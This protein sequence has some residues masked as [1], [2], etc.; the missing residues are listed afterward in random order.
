MLHIETVEPRTLSLL[1]KLMEIPSLQQFSLVGGT[2]LSLKYGHRTS[3]DLD[4]FFHEEFDHL[5][6]ENELSHEFGND[7]SYEIEY[8]KFG[9]FCYVQKIK[10]DIVYYPHLPIAEIETEDQIRMYS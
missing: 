6:I 3:V 4:L 9:V 5:K 1:K 10:V 7:F 2:A 8:K